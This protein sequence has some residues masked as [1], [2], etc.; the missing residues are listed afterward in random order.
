MMITM[1]IY[2][3]GGFPPTGPA[4]DAPACRAPSAGSPDISK[5]T[6]TEKEFGSTYTKNTSIGLEAP[7]PKINVDYKL[8]IYIYIYMYIYIY[9]HIYIYI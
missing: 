6:C 5:H 4:E 8:Y 9:I 3:R 7:I 1:M 2:Q